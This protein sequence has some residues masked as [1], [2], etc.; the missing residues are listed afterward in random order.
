MGWL[1]AWLVGLASCM[2][3]DNRSDLTTEFRSYP[4]CHVVPKSLVFVAVSAGGWLAAEGSS[5][6]CAMIRHEVERPQRSDI[7]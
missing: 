7:P 3:E 5:A 4:G 1:E 2:A 6:I